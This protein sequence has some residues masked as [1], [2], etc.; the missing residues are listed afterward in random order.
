MSYI[1]H[2]NVGVYTAFL[3]TDD[4]IAIGIS[5]QTT[6]KGNSPAFDVRNSL[7]DLEKCQNTLCLQVGCCNAFKLAVAM[8][9]NWMLLCLQVCCCNDSML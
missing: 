4:T 3:E 9:S 1:I 7:S 8:P 6:S 2:I 5:F